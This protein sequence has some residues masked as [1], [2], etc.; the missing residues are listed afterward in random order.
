MLTNDCLIGKYENLRQYGRF[1]EF[2]ETVRIE[3]LEAAFSEI[4]KNFGGIENYM[5]N[6]LAVDVDLLRT[7]YLE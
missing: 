7:L 4:D 5:K 6:Q 3:Y 1:V 2:F